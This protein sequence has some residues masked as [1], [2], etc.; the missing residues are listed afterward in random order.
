MPDEYP[1]NKDCFKCGEKVD[2][3]DSNKSCP[4]GTSENP[5]VQSLY[6][7]VGLGTTSYNTKNNYVSRDLGLRQKEF[8]TYNG[9]RVDLPPF[10]GSLTSEW[11]EKLMR[12]VVIGLVT[13]TITPATFT[14]ASLQLQ[15]EN[16]GNA[17]VKR[18]AANA[19]RQILSDQYLTNIIAENNGTTITSYLRS[20]IGTLNATTGLYTIPA[21]ARKFRTITITRP[22]QNSLTTC[23]I[24]TTDYSSSLTSP[25]VRIRRWVTNAGFTNWTLSHFADTTQPNKEYSRLVLEKTDLGN[26]ILQRTRTHSE[27]TADASL[28]VTKIT[29]EK[30]RDLG[31]GNLRIMEETNAL[32]T[33]EESTTTYTYTDATGT[34]TVGLNGVMTAPAASGSPNQL[35]G[36][37]IASVE[38]SSGS[39]AQYQYTY[40]AATKIMVTDQWTPWKNAAFG[41][42]TN[43]IRTTIILEESGRTVTQRIGTQIISDLKETLSTLPD[44]TRVIR[45][46]TSTGTTTTPLINETGYFAE[47][48]AE[49]NRGRI[50]Y[51][52]HNDGTL[53]SYSYTTQGSNIKTTTHNGVINAAQSAAN[54]TG[55]IS[56][57]FTAG[58]RSETITNAFNR[59]IAQ[60]SYDIA[61]NL[62][63]NQWDAITFDDVG[64]PTK[65]IHNLDPNDYEETTYNCCGIATRR[66]RDGTTTQFTRDFLGRETFTT[67]VTGSRTTNTATTFGSETI[68]GRNLPKTTRTRSVT[69]AGNTMSQFLGESIE[70]LA[71]QTILSRS[72]D[73]NGD[74]QPEE[75]T[76]SENIATRT[77][78][79]TGPD[80]TIST[81]TRYADGQ[82]HTSVTTANIGGSATAITPLTT[83]DYTLHNLNGGGIKTTVT[84]FDDNVVLKSSSSYADLAG[85]TIKTESPGY[86]GAILTS[87]PLYDERG[88]NI[89]A[90]RTGQPSMKYVLNLQGET[91]EVWTDANGDGE[92]NDTVVADIKDTCQK[93]TTDYVTEDGK[94]CQRSTQSLRTDANADVITATSYTSTDGLYRKTVPLAGTGPITTTTATRPNVAEASSLLAQSTTKTYLTA[95]TFLE[96]TTTTTLNAN[97]TTTTTQ[98]NKDTTGA[99]I[100]TAS[101]TNDIIGRTVSETG[102]RGLTTTY[103]NFT[104]AGQPLLTT[105]SDG[106]KTRITLDAAARPTK[107]ETLDATGAVKAT[108]FTS[109]H[110]SGQVAA[111]WGDLT[112]PTYK[113]YNI[114]GQMEELRT[115]KNIPAAQLNSPTLNLAAQSGYE[116]TNW[117]YEPATGLLLSKRYAD[118]KGPGYTYTADG[119]MY[120][121]DAS[122]LL[123]NSTIR[124]NKTHNYN[125]A[126]QLTGIDYNDT[127]PD[128]TITYNRLGQKKP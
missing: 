22:D 109:Y 13:E 126:G 116:K 19:L 92:F 111:E 37:R 71:G 86:N 58:T 52:R 60:A 5:E 10:N 6:Y 16:A 107:V 125:A 43:A 81:S 27:L 91:T 95:T 68:N 56:G 82:Q 24:T 65:I 87:P 120:M 8:S 105:H 90:T 46:S 23:D 9:P 17:W 76:Y 61:S 7:T 108:R 14:P 55:P 74:G 45:S 18:D 78:T 4:E 34:G 62:L 113:L 31:Q 64:R 11:G 30:Y 29:R 89:G 2:S 79:S 122:R 47:N 121:A 99:T 49:P 59:E 54:A 75:T 117:N 50:R 20:T 28:L 112:Y 100:T 110:S 96:S 124:L 114:Q 66:E 80:G 83:Y 118:E 32:G 67:S 69:S 88:R 98:T 12:P 115:F 102:E 41:D 94:V 123:A 103:S 63:L 85:R 57:T 84:Q 119:K 104:E 97:G 93:T 3:D 38:H 48:A 36:Y 77:T 21:T 1:Y 53:T 106:T 70:N 26:G 39:W 33:P 128:V 40:N 73:A 72:P 101:S 35:T 44:G 51:S 25:K 15:G 127:T 42:K